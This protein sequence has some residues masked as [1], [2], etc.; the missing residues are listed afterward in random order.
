MSIFSVAT[1]TPVRELFDSELMGWS[2]VVAA[3]VVIAVRAIFSL[4]MAI[5]RVLYL[6]APNFIIYQLGTYKFMG[7]LTFSLVLFNTLMTV[8]WVSNAHTHSGFLHFGMGI[9]REKAVILMKYNNEL[10][11]EDEIR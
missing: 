9:S 8:G 7:L 5:F 1:G 4:A 10:P 11:D 3:T 2:L 6:L